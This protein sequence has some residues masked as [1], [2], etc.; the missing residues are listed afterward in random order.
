MTK[1]GKVSKGVDMHQ[2]RVWVS[3]RRMWKLVWLDMFFNII[4]MKFSL[5]LFWNYICSPSELPIFYEE[6]ICH[7][8][9]I[10]I[11]KIFGFDFYI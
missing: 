6:N 9:D 1:Y 10:H 5:Y 3:F 8:D 11:V 7:I 4:Y 2:G